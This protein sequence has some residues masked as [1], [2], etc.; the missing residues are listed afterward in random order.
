MSGQGEA[1]SEGV[2]YI[3]IEDFEWRPPPDKGDSKAEP[4][5]APVREGDQS[6]EAAEDRSE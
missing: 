5:K 3:S 1:D 4:A 2:Y 6:E